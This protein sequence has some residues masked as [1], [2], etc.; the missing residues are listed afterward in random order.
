MDWG[1]NYIPLESDEN[2]E[3]EQ[4]KRVLTTTT[5]RQLS[6]RLKLNHLRVKLDDERSRFKELEAKNDELIKKIE[7]LQMEK[8]EL[9]H[10]VNLAVA[11]HAGSEEALSSL[12]DR[13]D[14]VQTQRLQE[15]VTAHGALARFTAIV[16]QLK[17]KNL[18]KK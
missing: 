11:L 17:E 5:A 10:K 6:M 15:K 12:K 16:N 3:N 1:A 8:N 13:L 9:L 2:K 4:K 7:A 18:L 14:R